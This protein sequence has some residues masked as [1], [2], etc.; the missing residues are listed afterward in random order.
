MFIWQSPH[1]PA[2]E[3]GMS[4][5]AVSAARQKKGIFGLQRA[6]AGQRCRGLQAGTPR[7]FFVAR[8]RVLAYADRCYEPDG[9]LAVGKPPME[10]AETGDHELV[11]F[12]F[13]VT[14]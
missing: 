5:P 13:D 10:A 11:I 9:M 2:P 1:L 6:K 4:L 7:T 14:N 8:Q 3:S 12:G